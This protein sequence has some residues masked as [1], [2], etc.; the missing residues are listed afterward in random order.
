MHPYK[1]AVGC[2]PPAASNRGEHGQSSKIVTDADNETVDVN[3]DEEDF[4]ERF[5]NSFLDG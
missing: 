4:D 5:L 1:I 2:V 3:L